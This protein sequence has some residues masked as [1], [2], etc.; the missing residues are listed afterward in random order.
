MD[1][2]F[3]T[4]T[5][6]V[7]C[8]NI[9]FE[10]FVWQ[11]KS[12]F[13]EAVNT[14]HNSNYNKWL[15]KE[16]E[17]LNN[18]INSKMEYWTKFANNKYKTEHGKNQFLEGKRTEVITECMKWNKGRQFDELTYFDFDV[19]PW[20]NGIHGF[21]V[22][23]KEVLESENSLKALYEH[24]TNN[25][26]FKRAKGWAFYNYPGFRPKIELIVD[27]ETKAEMEADAKNL[28]DSI[29]KF[30]EGCRYWGD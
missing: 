30:Y 14:Y 16:Y 2:V 19:E 18:S 28:S 15:Q 9:S 24:L 7:D 10:N 8:S 21:C 11:L 23:T 1:K 4:R 12:T 3:L 6:N 5:W 13:R 25:K 29:A 22:I 20:E 26:Y 17:N 27:E